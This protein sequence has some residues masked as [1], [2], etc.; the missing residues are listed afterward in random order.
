MGG[1]ILEVTHMSEAKSEMLD[2]IH[3]REFFDIPVNISKV[4][5]IMLPPYTTFS[6]EIHGELPA[7][8]ETY[9]YVVHG[10]LVVHADPPYDHFELFSGDVVHIVENSYV[11]TNVG[12]EQ[13]LI[14]RVV[15]RR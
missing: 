13:A 3:I 7:A 14:F 11:L 8:E 9:L 4:A 2:L 10:Y 1:P 12:S 15:H 6:Q 5:T